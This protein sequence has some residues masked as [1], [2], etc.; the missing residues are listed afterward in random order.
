MSAMAIFVCGGAS[1]PGGASI[2]IRIAD[3]QVKQV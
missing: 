1:A 3:R 2:P